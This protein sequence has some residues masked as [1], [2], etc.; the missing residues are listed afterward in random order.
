[1]DYGSVAYSCQK[2]G[3]LF[4]EGGVDSGRV[5]YRCLKGV[6]YTQRRR[7]DSGRVAYLFKR[8]GYILGGRRRSWECCT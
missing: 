7:V 1:M 3:Y 6:G 4:W 8:E 2:R 5:V